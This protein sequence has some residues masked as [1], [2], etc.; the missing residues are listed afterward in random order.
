MAISRLHRR[1]FLQPTIHSLTLKV[2]TLKGWNPFFEIYNL[3]ST[4]FQTSAKCWRTVYKNMLSLSMKLRQNTWK[5]CVPRRCAGA[6]RTFFDKGLFAPVNLS[7][8]LAAICG[9]KKMPRTEAIK[10]LWV[11]I[12]KNS[13]SLWRSWITSDHLIVKWWH[14]EC[15]P[16]FT[17]Y[18]LTTVELFFTYILITAG[19]RRASGVRC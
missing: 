6:T 10:K 14:C 11:Y 1:R 16:S 13:S 12:K 17:K 9:G 7:A 18:L 2:L 5:P 4:A 8:S 15:L 19:G 3:F